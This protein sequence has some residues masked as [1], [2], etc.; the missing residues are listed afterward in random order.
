M[1]LQVDNQ[2]CNSSPLHNWNQNMIEFTSLCAYSNWNLTHWS[3][4]ARNKADKLVERNTT[5]AIFHIHTQVGVDQG[6]NVYKEVAAT[7]K[8]QDVKIFLLDHEKKLTQSIIDTLIENPP[9]HMLKTYR[10]KPNKYGKWTYVRSY[11]GWRGERNISY[12][13]VETS[14]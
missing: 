9:Q 10:I 13:G 2:A 3:H 1:S 14:P 5:C 12:K 7:R 4:E 8:K 11:L 6:R